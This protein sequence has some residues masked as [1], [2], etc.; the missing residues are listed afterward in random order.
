MANVKAE[1]RVKTALGEFLAAFE[2]GK[3]AALRLPGSW[4]RTSG[5]PLLAGR[6]GRSGRTLA[7]QL[8]DFAAGR[9]VRFSVPLAPEGTP[10]QKRVWA[11]LRRVPRGATVTYAELA[12]RAGHPGAARAAGSACGANPIAVVTPC[13]RAVAADGP[14]GFGAGLAW[15]RR[16]LRLEG[17]EL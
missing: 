12:R 10:F 17:R 8:G 4:R 2:G 7:R 3:L 6:E 14:G 13:H 16:L 15:K 1:Y 11:E 9:R 5:T